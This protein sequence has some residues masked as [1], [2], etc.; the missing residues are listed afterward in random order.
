MKG[1]QRMKKK[2]YKKG[3]EVRDKKENRGRSEGG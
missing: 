3:K 2:C 1:R